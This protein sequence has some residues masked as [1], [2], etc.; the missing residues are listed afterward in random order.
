VERRDP[1]VV[2]RQWAE[3]VEGASLPCGHFVA[4]EQP[5]ATAEALQRFFSKT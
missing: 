2:W 5:E 1:R 4:E 3:D